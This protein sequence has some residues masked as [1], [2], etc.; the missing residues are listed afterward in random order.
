[1]PTFAAVNEPDVGTIPFVTVSAPE[2]P[3]TVPEHDPPVYIVIVTVP[4]AVADAP[5]KADESVTDPP[6]TT[7][8]A[9]RRVDSVGESGFTVSCSHGL[10]AGLFSPSPV[11]TAW[12]L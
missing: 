8:V 10:V 6:W 12:K 5:D 4:P 1:M 2:L 7:V 3:T 9:D 11:Y